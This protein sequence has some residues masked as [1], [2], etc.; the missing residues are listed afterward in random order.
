MFQSVCLVVA[1]EI[2]LQSRVLLI[3]MPAQIISVWTV[4]YSVT[5]RYTC[6]PVLYV[7]HYFSSTLVIDLALV[8]GNN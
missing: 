1:S 8:I 6:F 3:I 7:P 4:I 2:H 5:L